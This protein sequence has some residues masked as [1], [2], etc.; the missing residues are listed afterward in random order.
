MV[1]GLLVVGLNDLQ[2]FSFQ[3]AWAIGGVCF[4]ESVRKRV[5][6]ITPL[7][8]VGVVVVCQLQKAADEQD[9]IRQTTKFCLFATGLV[10]TL[11]SIILAC[12]NLPKEIENRVIFTIV[13]KPTTRLEVVLGKVLGFARVT[14]LILLIMGVFTYVYLEIRTWKKQGDL[15][16]RLQTDATLSPTERD[17]LEHYRQAGLLT[18]M[19]FD[20]P[21]ALEIFAHD[22]GV[23]HTTAGM[24]GGGEQD[25]IVPFAVDR[26]RMF[27]DQAGQVGPGSGFGETGLIIGVKVRWERYGPGGKQSQAAPAPAQAGPGVV[28][29]EPPA[30]SVDL[31]DAAQTA[32]VT[33][34]QMFDPNHPQEKLAHANALQLPAENS[35]RRSGSMD[36]AKFVY[37]YVGPDLCTQIYKQPEIYVHVTGNSN[38]V[39]YTADPSSVFLEVSPAIPPALFAPPTPIIEHIPP[40]ARIRPD[41][42]PD[43]KSTP[44]IFRGRQALSG[45]QQLKGGNPAK[46][47]HTPVAVYQFRGATVR[48]AGSADVPFEMKAGIERGGSD[49]EVDRE[50]PTDVTLVFR[51]AGTGKESA[52][53]DVK[54]ESKRT[55]YT[56]VPAAAVSGGD[57]DV[58]VR[59]NTPGHNLGLDAASLSLATNQ[60]SFVWNLLKS[61][62]IMWMMT[63]LV[64][65]IAIF[66]STFLSWPIAIVLT[67]VLLLG[68]WGTEQVSDTTGTAPGR[69]V[70]QDIFGAKSA[71]NNEVV[72][73]SV[74]ACRRACRRWARCC[75]TSTSSPRSKTSRRGT[76]WVG[77][78]SPPRWAC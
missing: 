7:T 57:F 51:D 1:V 58:V 40:E 26:E 2:R 25:F 42:G 43:G 52:P 37:A 28:V 60:Q 64:V 45:G 4:R 31:F 5:L 23:N 59:C 10:V 44:P 73:S 55:A 61:L 77:R 54:L 20:R 67:C 38:N 76:S 9:A 53:V 32:M 69:S 39:E 46:D 75:R 48:E 30:L 11:T 21:K 41:A 22:P 8:I 70:A 74:S 49:L 19:S 50:E 14:A 71:S 12:T 47:P 65:A 62:L 15:A 17:T 36:D 18:A 34:D 24:Y 35:V 6:W 3:R 29:E 78:R 33:G 27:R 16:A 13:T 68:H 72:V 63:V 56:S 66:C